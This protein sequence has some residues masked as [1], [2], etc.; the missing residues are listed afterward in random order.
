ML[1]LQ[2][3]EDCIVLGTLY[4]EMKLKP[5][6]LDEYVKDLGLPRPLPDAKFTSPDDSLLLEDEGARVRLSG[7]ALPVQTLASGICLAVRGRS[8][9]PDFH[10]HQLCFTPPGPQTPLPG[11][12][13]PAAAAPD[14]EATYV[15]L[16]SGLNLGASGA[17]A[18]DPL[19]PQLLTDWLSGCLGGEAEQKLASRVVRCI[20]AGDC[21]CSV[22]PPT[23]NVSAREVSRLTAPL[24]EADALLSQLAA[25]LPVDLMP[26]R[27]DAAN[28]ALPQQPL[29]PCL[30]PESSRFDG[31]AA[32][33]RV[34]NPH[35]CLLGGVRLLG[36]S[37]QN[38]DDLY[39]CTG[40]EERLECA[41]ATLQWGHLAPSA[42]DT[43][44]C[45]PFSDRDPF[46]M[47]NLPHLYFVGNQPGYASRLMR[48]AGGGVTRVVLVPRFCSTG[49]FV[50]VNLA[51]LACHPITF[52]TSEMTAAA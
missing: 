29:H 9:G 46:L 1:E 19:L 7:D 44:S 51:T 12:G 2:D 15:A 20:V 38:V 32:L 11:A 24:K 43:L 6:I 5:S 4:K 47:P 50:L 37:G 8:D 39:R 42:P 52:S 33:R 21:V 13:A 28:S 10:V 30:L 41:V 31:P 45:H 25:A 48:G 34:T 14:T 3:G 49:T 40:Q 18:G 16:V 22:P 27:H 17:G 26:G 23:G 36:T 35:Q